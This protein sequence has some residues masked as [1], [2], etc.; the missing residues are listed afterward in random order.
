MGG[1]FAIISAALEPGLKAAFV[2]SSGSY[3]LQGNDDKSQRFI[4]SIEPTGYLSLLPP[5]KVAFFHFSGDTII[6][7]A[8]GKQLYNSAS[9]P[10]AWH[11]YDGTVHGLYSDVY[12]PDL[13][14]ELRSVFGR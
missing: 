9:Q 3:G 2:V 6:P 1:R 11:E 10:K 13:H 7:V 8:S 14:D 5:R 4:R 12:A